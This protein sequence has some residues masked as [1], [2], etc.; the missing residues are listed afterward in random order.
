MLE[1]LLELCLQM[2]LRVL[3]QNQNQNQFLSLKPNVVENSSL[4]SLLLQQEQQMIL[5][6]EMCVFLLMKE[7]V[8][9]KAYDPKVGAI[10]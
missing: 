1:R 5:N 7:R 3:Q 2:T 8:F 4:K 9:I 6:L 10:R